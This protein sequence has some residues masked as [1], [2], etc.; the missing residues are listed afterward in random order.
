MAPSKPPSKVSKPIKKMKPSKPMELFEFEVAENGDKREIKWKTLH[1][2]NRKVSFELQR[3]ISGTAYQTF[4]I[5][6]SRGNSNGDEENKYQIEDTGPH[7]SKD[8]LAY[9][10]KEVK[11]GGAVIYYKASVKEKKKNIEE[12]SSAATIVGPVLSPDPNTGLLKV[13][14]SIEKSGDV[15]IQ[16]VDAQ[17]NEKLESN[18]INQKSGNYLKSIDMSKMPT[19]KYLLIIKRNENVVNEV[20]IEKKA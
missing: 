13:K 4:A 15:Y 11:S 10:L 12:K 6:S 8:R 14:Y 5:V 17:Q 20:H 19:G 18:Y 9:R 1:E 3:S 7:L 16:L 2:A